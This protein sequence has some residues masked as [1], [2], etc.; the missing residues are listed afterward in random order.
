MEEQVYQDLCQKGDTI[1]NLWIAVIASSE[2]A[3][4]TSCK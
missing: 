2:F 3:H 1:V 4:E